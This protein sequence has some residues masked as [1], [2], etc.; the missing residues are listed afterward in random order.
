METTT[1]A[2]DIAELDV[3]PT[4]PAP[5]PAP[6]WQRILNELDLESIKTFDDAR[7][8][9]VARFDE[10]R[11]KYEAEHGPRWDL[12][13]IGG[14][15]GENETLHRRRQLDSA[16][17]F[18]TEVSLGGNVVFTEDLPADVQA[19]IWSA[20]VEFGDEAGKWPNDVLA[21]IRHAPKRKTHEELRSARRNALL[22][23]HAQIFARVLKDHGA[24]PTAWP[25]E[26]LDEIARTQ[27]RAQALDI[28]V[29][30]ASR[31]DINWHKRKP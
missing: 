6:E 31:S 22:T 26:A 27:A 11:V 7:R 18:R 16:R 23:E 29:D 10:W 9:L 17:K 30:A 15:D 21:K 12:H 25:I 1:H 14:F 20:L 4:P 19:L 2:P 28:L 3:Q 24:N 13:L 5:P 8:V